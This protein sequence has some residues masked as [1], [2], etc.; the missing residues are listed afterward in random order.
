REVTHTEK[1][2][3]KGSDGKELGTK[4]ATIVETIH[5]HLDNTTGDEVGDSR[6]YSKQSGK[7]DAVDNPNFDGYVL[8][9]KESKAVAGDNGGTED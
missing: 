8:N 6:D 7:F 9:T 4:T 2:V 5:A 3:Y 1:I